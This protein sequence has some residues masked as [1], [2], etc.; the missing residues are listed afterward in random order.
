M[1]KVIVVSAHPDDEVLGCGGTLLK[2]KANGDEIY[3]LIITNIFEHQGFSQER[4][5]SRQV[6]IE[7]VSQMF[8]CTQTHKLDFP[9]MS[10]G[11]KEGNEMIPMISKIFQEVEPEII[12]VMNR[13]DAHSDHRVSFD[14]VVACT[15]SFR[16]PYVKRVLMYECISET[17]FAPALFEKVFLPN[18]FVDISPYFE[19]KIEIM[20]VY[21]SELGE[22]PFPRS[23]RNIEALA[24]FRGASVGVEYAEAFQLVKYIDK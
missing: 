10:L 15:K 4:I 8:G 7:K 21:E 24:T 12:Y 3:W 20:G 22:H 16:Y 6:E 13:S 5:D 11:S 23:N 2:H 14:A 19:R 17:E 18:Y 9:T 1:S